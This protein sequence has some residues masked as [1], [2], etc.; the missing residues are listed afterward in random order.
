MLGYPHVL[1]EGTRAML[2]TNRFAQ[3]GSR[4]GTLS[5]DGRDFAVD[6]DVWLG[7]RTAR[8]A[9]GRAASR[10]PPAGGPPSRARASG[11][12]TFRFAPTTTRWRCPSRRVPTGTAR[13]TTRTRHPD[14]ARLH[15]TTPRGEP[16][17]LEVGNLG[18][19]PLSMGS[20]YASDPAW[21]HGRWM[22]REWSESVSDDMTSPD[23]VAMLPFN[24][25]DHV[26]R[27]TC[28]GDVGWGLFGH[29]N[30]GCHDPLGFTDWGDMAK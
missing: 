20:G 19:V 2:D 8:G 12:P 24:T 27:A 16:L 5:V 25:V 17:L 21:S 26:A 28:N 10:T 7:T 18:G 23:V 15:L 6:L 29:A 11:G 14:C 1:F 30:L 9:S 13:S 22:G 3:V 4:S